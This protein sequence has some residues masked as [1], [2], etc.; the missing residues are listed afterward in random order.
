MTTRE[1]IAKNPIT[2]SIAKFEAVQDKYSSFGAYDT[3]PNYMFRHALRKHFSGLEVKFGNP[4]GKDGED[5][6]QIYT[7]MAGWRK[8]N[9]AMTSACKRV[10]KAMDKATMKQI[11]EV[12]D[13]YDLGLEY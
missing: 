4:A 5:F 6:W 3:E 10:L 8:A 7:S 12:A 1:T 11:R 9:R 13:Y 2:R